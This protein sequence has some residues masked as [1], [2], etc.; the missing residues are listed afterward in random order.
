VASASDDDIPVVGRVPVATP[1]VADVQGPDFSNILKA[2]S[3]SASL[4]VTRIAN[5][6]G[7]HVQRVDASGHV[8]RQRNRAL[9]IVKFLANAHRALSIGGEVV[10]ADGV[11]GTVL[12]HLCNARDRAA[13]RSK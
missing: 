8:A 10:G 6:A 9:A 3:A 13:R 11:K 12:E 1:T 5:L 7:S 4:D 2:A